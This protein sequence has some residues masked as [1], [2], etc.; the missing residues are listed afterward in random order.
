MAQEAQW[1]IQEFMLQD[2]A[3]AM[4]ADLLAQTAFVGGCTTALLV[5][6]QIVR[7]AALAALLRHPDFGYVL[8]S[9]AGVS[10]GREPVFLKRIQTLLEA[11]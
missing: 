6:D 3:G 8:Q 11:G 9:M 10:P 1:Q 7:A 4:G 5:T 2:V